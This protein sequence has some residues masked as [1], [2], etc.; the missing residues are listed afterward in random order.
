VLAGDF[1]LA[2]AVP[3]VMHGENLRDPVLGQRHGTIGVHVLGGIAGPASHLLD[4]AFQCLIVLPIP[5]V[6]VADAVQ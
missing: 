1:D 4:I 6:G 2:V 5:A 3:D